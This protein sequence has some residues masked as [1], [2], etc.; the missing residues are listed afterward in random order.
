MGIEPAPSVWKT[1]VLPLNY[2]RKKRRKV[3]LQSMRPPESNQETSGLEPLSHTFAGPSRV[4]SIVPNCGAKESAFPA[5]FG[6]IFCR[7]I[8]LLAP[9]SHGRH[10]CRCYAGNR[11]LT[12]LADFRPR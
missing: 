8:A 5:N 4:D 2:I 3:M 10:V 6:L 1:D 12:Q 7:S 9:D 11:W